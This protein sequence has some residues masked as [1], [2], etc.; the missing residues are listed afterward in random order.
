MIKQHKNVVRNVTRWISLGENRVFFKMDLAR[1]ECEKKMD[2]ARG[3]WLFMM[4]P[5]GAK[6]SRFS[7]MD[8]AR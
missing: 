6:Y 2:L 8:L 5:D 7:K 1:G 3:E 4:S